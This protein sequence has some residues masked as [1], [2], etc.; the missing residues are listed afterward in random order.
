MSSPAVR[1][2]DKGLGLAVTRA[3]LSGRALVTYARDHVAV[4]TPSHPDHYDGNTIDLLAPPA[5][6]DVP[7]WLDRF[8]GTIGQLGARV[9]SLRW[10]QPLPAD[11]PAAPVA[12]DVDLARAFA[13]H[14]MDLTPVTVLLLTE[15]SPAPPAVAEL[16]PASDERRWHAAL[17]LY[18][19][20]DPAPDADW[21]AWDQ[22]FARWTVELHRELAASGRS[23]TWLAYRQGAPVG[24]ATITHDRQGLAVVEDVVVHPAHR[25]RG[26]ASLL[27]HRAVAH[28]LDAHPDARVGIG[29]EPGSSAERLYRRLGFVPHAT[30]WT[31]R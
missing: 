1:R 6:A 15:L 4:R 21:R 20:D 22:G 7:G 25:R 19:Y 3:G 10:E 27:V 12:P 5:A 9:V 14:G 11:A 16:V 2:L 31:A 17:V 26:V 24:R 30:V 23:V 8:R 18:R 28:H 29:C 13:A